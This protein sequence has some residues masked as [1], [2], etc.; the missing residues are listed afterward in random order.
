[1][2]VGNALKNPRLT[3]RGKPS[4]LEI[5][6]LPESNSRPSYQTVW[7]A[8]FIEGCKH[9]MSGMFARASVESGI[10]AHVMP[11]LKW[12]QMPRQSPAYIF[13]LSN[14]FIAHC[15]LQE[16]AG[17]G[18]T[19]EQASTQSIL[20]LFLSA[21][22]TLLQ[23]YNYRLAILI[24]CNCNLKC[25][26]GKQS[27]KGMTP[28]RENP[29]QNPLSCHSVLCWRTVTSSKVYTQPPHAA[30]LSSKLAKQHIPSLGGN[31]KMSACRSRCAVRN[32]ISK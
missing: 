27:S 25:A 1:M 14:R 23:P 11:E 12:T 15:E 5:S 29:E 3:I 21:L 9:W 20:V 6:W 18:W 16:K 32:T 7:L 8:A 2:C 10:S 26:R 13:S 28:P 24:A 4:H 30:L 31:K 19:C 17:S 22:C